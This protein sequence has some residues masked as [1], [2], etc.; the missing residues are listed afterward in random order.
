MH[1]PVAV[2]HKCIA[3]MVWKLMSKYYHVTKDCTGFI[4]HDCS[5]VNHRVITSYCP[6]LRLLQNI[7]VYIALS[8]PF[9]FLC[10]GLQLVLLQSW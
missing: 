3:C 2:F 9:N 8:V 7:T 10:T 6:A 1:V 4:V 5:V